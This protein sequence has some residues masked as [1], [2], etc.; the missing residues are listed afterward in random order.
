M[1]E[2]RVSASIIINKAVRSNKRFFKNRRALMSFSLAF[3]DILSLLISYWLAVFIR[4]SI[5]GQVIPSVYVELAYLAPLAILRL[6][7]GRVI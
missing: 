5:I 4:F 6:F 3:F 7:V 1:E 2:E